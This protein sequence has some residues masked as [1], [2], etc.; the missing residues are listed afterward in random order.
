MATTATTAPTCQ[1][2]TSSVCSGSVSLDSELAAVYP[3]GLLP[4]TPNPA[5]DRV[6]S[7][8]TGMLTQPTVDTIVGSLKQSGV[9]PSGTLASVDQFESKRTALLEKMKAEYCHYEIRYK[10]A[11]QK[12]FAA[13]ID[14]G[15]D[16]SNATKKTAVTTYLDFCTR[17]NLRLN[18]LIQITNGISAEILRTADSTQTEID[19]FNTTLKDQQS[20]LAAQKEVIQSNDATMK[21]QKQMVRYTE[22]KARRSDF[23]LKVYG[24]VN[25]V[26]VGLLLYVYRGSSSS[27]SGG[28]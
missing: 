7:V 6:Q 28:M 3:S 13:V 25:V 24:V 8:A 15:N 22:E 23:L 11:L 27:P 2:S 21:L 18:D 5:S 14:S 26:A 19:Q 9:I 20:R 1:V 4:S 17:L 16:P 10:S 12:L